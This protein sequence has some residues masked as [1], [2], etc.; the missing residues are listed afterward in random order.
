MRS[1]PKYVRFAF[2]EEQDPDSHTA[3]ASGD[4]YLRDG[5]GRLLFL[6]QPC[7]PVE[8][9]ESVFFLKSNN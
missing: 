2:L 5:N 7:E 3:V 9:D 4:G 8:T 6:A 1:D